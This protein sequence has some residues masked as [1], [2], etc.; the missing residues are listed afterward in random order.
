MAPSFRR[1]STAS[2]ADGG[3]VQSDGLVS[4]TAEE[5]GPTAGAEDGIA[6]DADD[7]EAAPRETP[8]DETETRWSKRSRVST[9]GVGATAVNEPA[10]HLNRRFFLGLNRASARRRAR[11]RREAMRRRNEDPEGVHAEE[12]RAENDAEQQAARSTDQQAA[13]SA[14]RNSE[15]RRSSVLRFIRNLSSYDPELPIRAT[16][17]EEEPEASQGEI[18]EAKRS[19]TTAPTTAPTY[20]PRPTLDI[21][22]S[23]GFVRCGM[24]TDQTYRLQLCRA[25]AAVV[26]GDP[27]KYRVVKLSSSDRFVKLQSRQ[28][29]LLLFSDTHT[30]EREINERTTGMGFTFSDPYY[31]SGLG[32]LGYETFVKC[33]EEQIRY[34]QCQDLRICVGTDTTHQDILTQYFPSDF[35]V[36]VSFDNMTAYLLNGT[37]NVLVT[38]SPDYFLE[39][40]VR[41]ANGT[42]DGLSVGDKFLEMEPLAAVT[43]QSDREFSDVVN[44]VINSMKYAEAKNIT[45][46]D[47]MCNPYEKKPSALD[48][49]YMNAVYCVG[50]YADLE[51]YKR[52]HGR[53]DQRDHVQDV[54][55]GYIEWQ[56][57]Q[58]KSISVQ[59]ARKGLLGLDEWDD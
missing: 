4:E 7:D 23:N 24:D 55:G 53:G 50:N 19:L 1:R 40:I 27:E 21:I 42:V 2:R 25:V 29:D 11:L 52:N 15:R 20:D 57:Q 30:M 10:P 59:R 13:I 38:D 45:K 54:G 6:D 56:S 3:E 58:G 28:V 9:D 18:V 34:D 39:E 46:D 14:G 36:G 26:F 8:N 37:C 32:Y 31:F 44:W 17:V 5:P 51:F 35:M 22:Q 47:S 41:E 48:L 49:N 12:Q 33:A 43:R 16:L